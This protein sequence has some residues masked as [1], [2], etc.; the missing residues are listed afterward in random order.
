M[1]PYLKRVSSLPS[2]HRLVEG[3]SSYSP[4]EV[5]ILAAKAVSFYCEI[6]DT[7]KGNVYK[8]YRK[9]GLKSSKY[10]LELNKISRILQERVN[11]TD[12]SE[13][14]PDEVLPFMSLL[15][16]ANGPINH[17]IIA[18]F[19]S[20]FTNL[21]GFG[22][23]DLAN[24]LVYCRRLRLGPNIPHVL[25][26]ISDNMDYLLERASLRDI[27]LLLNTL[28]MYN[29]GNKTKYKLDHGT[30]NRILEHLNSSRI[31]RESVVGRYNIFK[32]FD[33]DVV[34]T[35]VYSNLTFKDLTNIFNAIVRHV[36]SDYELSIKNLIKESTDKATVPSEERCAG[37]EDPIFDVSNA[38]NNALYTFSNNSYRLISQFISQKMDDFQGIIDVIDSMAVLGTVLEISEYTHN[39]MI[40]IVSALY[41]RI[42]EYLSCENPEPKYFYGTHMRV[43]MRNLAVFRLHRVNTVACISKY[44]GRSMFWSVGGVLDCLNAVSFFGASITDENR[45]EHLVQILNSSTAHTEV[46]RNLSTLL[47]NSLELYYSCHINLLERLLR[48]CLGYRDDLYTC[49]SIL[50]LYN[51]KIFSRLSVGTLDALNRSISQYN[52][53]GHKT[54]RSNVDESLEFVD[55][56]MNEITFGFSDTT[57]CSLF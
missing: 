46:H 18:L 15:S 22:I 40:A 5:K 32:G 10:L 50:H 36:S 11:S 23:S 29:C 34:D 39:R 42:D 27:C 8:L 56:R 9:G 28:R 55:K 6:N 53:K 43:I 21:A 47:V 24:M 48:R 3:I 17:D 19:H 12:P 57:A 37:F 20:K 2:L 41:D 26:Y 4:L 14:T 51:H 35:D 7:H 44:I 13:W 25:S 38:P 49:L 31:F 54:F 33:E 1:L 30:L 16:R 45:C 52:V